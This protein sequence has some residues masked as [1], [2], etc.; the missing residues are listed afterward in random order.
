MVTR[1]ER[2]GRLNQPVRAVVALV[3]VLVAAALVWLAVQM[4][5]QGIARITDHANDGT[6]LISSRYFGN[7][8]AGAIA[9][10]TIAVLLVL[11]ALR[12][13][14]LALRARPKRKTP[15]PAPLVDDLAPTA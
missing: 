10:G 11:D 9:V 3:E 15:E 7:W 6:V 8:A 4:W 1:G 5:P 13:L 14:V 12:Q 2:N